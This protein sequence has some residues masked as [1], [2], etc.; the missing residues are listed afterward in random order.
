MDYPSIDLEA[1]G[2]NLKAIMKAR[3]VTVKD[4]M[5]VCHVTNQSVYR[6]LDGQTLPKI[7]NLYVIAKYLG[8]RMEQIIKTSCQCAN[9]DMKQD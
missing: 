7:D 4:I 3:G 2:K 1:T 8:V 5:N 9:T 6:W